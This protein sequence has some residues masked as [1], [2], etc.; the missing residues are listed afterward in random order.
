MQQSGV[1]PSVRLSI[2][3]IRPVLVCCCGPGDCGDFDRLLH[4]RRAGGQQ[5]SRRS[6]STA[7]SSKCVHCHVSSIPGPWGHFFPNYQFLTKKIR[8]YVK[9]RVVWEKSD[10]KGPVY[11]SLCQ[12]TQK[13]ERGLVLC[14]SGTT[15]PTP[16]HVQD[17]T[18]YIS[19]ADG[20]RTTQRRI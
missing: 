4:G 1:R 11:Y 8:I 10:P 9:N 5:Q 17:V 20:L 12:R 3:T 15:I 16:G 19:I 7:R 6:R 18:Q 13:A 14:I 2:C